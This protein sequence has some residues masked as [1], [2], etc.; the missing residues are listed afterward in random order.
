MKNSNAINKQTSA[1]MVASLVLMPLL[2][3]LLPIVVL[4]W[5]CFLLHPVPAGAQE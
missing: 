2:L 1:R 4:S 3:P 5:I